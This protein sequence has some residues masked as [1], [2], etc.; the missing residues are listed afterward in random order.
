MKVTLVAAMSSNRVIGIDNKLPWH[1]PADLKF[2]KE[3]TLEKAII[4]GRKTFDSIG[5]RALPRRQN[6]VIT[7]N[8]NY[9]ADGA[10]V[11]GSIAEALQAAQAANMEAMI[12]GGTQIF[13]EAINTAATHIYLTIIHGDFEGDSYFPELDPTVWKEIWREDHAADE[14]NAYPY[15]FTLLEKQQ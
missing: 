2:F 3:T 5:K 7:S 1:M 10:I 4:M 13:T 6:I 15:S 11:V 8:P 12:V 9:I 14:K